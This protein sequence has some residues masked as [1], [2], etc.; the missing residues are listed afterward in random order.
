MFLQHVRNLN[1]F[2]VIGNHIFIVT[3]MFFWNEDIRIDAKHG[4]KIFSSPHV[5]SSQIP[6]QKSNVGVTSVPIMPRLGN[7]F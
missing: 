1:N 3:K 7:P 2:G 6:I 4:E 5:L